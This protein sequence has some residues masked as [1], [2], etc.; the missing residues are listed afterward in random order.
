MT[1]LYDDEEY[2]S[3]KTRFSFYEIKI[4]L[5][6]FFIGIF[7]FFSPLSL[8]Y[9]SNFHEVS[10]KIFGSILMLTSFLALFHI[11]SG[12][13]MIP[14][15]SLVL[16]F[17]VI[18]YVPLAFANSGLLGFLIIA[19][20]SMSLKRPME[21]EVGPTIPDNM[22]YN[23]S[24]VCKRFL[25]AL[26]CS[27][28]L[29][30]DRYFVKF[31]ASNLLACLILTSS[32]CFIFNL[33]GGRHR[34]HT[35]PLTVII[36]FLMM[37]TSA[38]LTA[39]AYFIYNKIEFFIGYLSLMTGA[40]FSID[41][42][43]ASFEYLFSDDR[44]TKRTCTLM[45]GSDFYN[46]TTLWDD[47]TAESPEKNIRNSLRGVSFPIN[48]IA[49][50]TVGVLAKIFV[51]GVIVNSGIQKLISFFSIVITG[52][53]CLSFAK[54]MRKL[55]LLNLIPAFFFIMS[56]IIFHIHPKSDDFLYSL[57]TGFIILICSIRKG[58]CEDKI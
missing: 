7:L 49:V 54:Q 37:I 29:I 39:V 4:N 27:L 8:G 55:R 9:E 6:L 10:D 51:T 14:I 46:T 3:L 43:K 13:L 47:K 26:L 16:Y 34:W 56:P 2:K 31:H 17:S 40:A 5:I 22:S 48:L 21:L 42:A 44:K 35:R 18:N 45:R 15:G 20:R 11:K 41:E 32:L 57:S 30:G 52:I 19:V 25:V 38:I 12:F 58:D 36:N 28:A 23:P 24:N 50:F 33:S 53:V 1:A